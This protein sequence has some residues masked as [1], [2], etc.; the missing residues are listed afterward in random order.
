M[1]PKKFRVFRQ[2]VAHQQAA[3]AAALDAKMRRVGDAALGEVAR[4]GGK[5]FVGFVAVFFQGCL[6][7][8]RAVFAAAT[9]VGDDVHAARPSWVRRF[10]QALPTPAA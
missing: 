8:A 6:V 2:H 5:V 1:A 7:P 9:D 10:S 4:D 3:V